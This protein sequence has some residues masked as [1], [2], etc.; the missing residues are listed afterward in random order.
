MRCLAYILYISEDCLFICI[1]CRQRY[2]HLRHVSWQDRDQAC[3]NREWRELVRS[4]DAVAES[5]ECA[6]NVVAP[7]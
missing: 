3:N 5:D 7:K 4:V 1:F 6:T 2:P